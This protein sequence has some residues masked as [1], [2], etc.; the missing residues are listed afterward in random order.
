M[1]NKIR[2]LGII[3]IIAIIGFSFLTCEQAYEEPTSGTLTITGLNDYIG[4]NIMA[5]GYA[6]ATDTIP[7]LVAAARLNSDSEYAPAKV[8]SGGVAGL[9]VW[10][11]TSNEGPYLAFDGSTQA[12]QFRVICEKEIKEGVHGVIGTVNVNFQGGGTGEG[13]FVAGTIY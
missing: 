9:K 4:E 10:K 1:K 6:N 5:W 3:A 8:S 12:V 2:L 11:A 13:N 7:I